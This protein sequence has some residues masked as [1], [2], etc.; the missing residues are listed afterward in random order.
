MVLSMSF[1]HHLL[2]YIAETDIHSC[3]SSGPVF[4]TAT[5]EDSMCMHIYDCSMCSA[6]SILLNAF[7][8]SLRSLLIFAKE[9]HSGKLLLTLWTLCIRMADTEE[10]NS[11][12][13]TVC[14][15]VVHMFF[16]YLFM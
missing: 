3:L 15:F 12:F 14:I 6:R 2:K 13:C 7:F 5:D 11:Q 8:I 1:R 16:S 10:S 4:E 9:E